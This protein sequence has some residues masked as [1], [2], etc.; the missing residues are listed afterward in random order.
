MVTEQQRSLCHRIAGLLTLALMNGPASQHS[1]Q[2]PL[3][4]PEQSEYHH[5]GDDN[6]HRTTGARYADAAATTC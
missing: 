3:G 6:L 5:D 1:G 4:Y 2:E